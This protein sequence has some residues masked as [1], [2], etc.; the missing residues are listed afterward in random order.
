LKDDKRITS[1]EH[2]SNW[3]TEAMQR[4]QGIPADL[5]QYI[6]DRAWCPHCGMMRTMA[7]DGGTIIAGD[8]VIAGTCT[9]CG[10]RMA[11]LLEHETPSS[12]ASAS[13]PFQPGESVIWL[14]RLPGGPYVVPLIA[15]VLAITPKR[16]KIRADDDGR[17]ITRFV[18]SES[19]Q[20]RQ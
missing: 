7:L 18:P 10:H 20:R 3:T 4:W 13:P 15:T 16:I 11:R 14:K 12:P 6:L 2:M 8:L 19:L 17:M 9:V 5:Q 1:P